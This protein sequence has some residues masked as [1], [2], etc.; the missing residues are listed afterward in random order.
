M[1]SF[2]NTNYKIWTVNNQLSIGDGKSPAG[3]HDAVLN[4]FSQNQSDFKK[5]V[6]IHGEDNSDSQTLTNSLI[7]FT[8]AVLSSILIAVGTAC[9]QV[10][11]EK[12]LD[13]R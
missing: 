8:L 6:D 10:S 5:P 1:K 12:L 4:N 13:N 2:K 7:S 9:V 11:Q 3:G